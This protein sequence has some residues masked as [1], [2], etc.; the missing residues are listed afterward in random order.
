[1]PALDKWFHV[2]DIKICFPHWILYDFVIRIMCFRYWR[3]VVALGS[4]FFSFDYTFSLD[5]IKC[6]FSLVNT[7]SRLIVYFQVG[8]KFSTGVESLSVG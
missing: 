5:K 4:A 6:F 7:L 1:M 2:Y 8:N 3:T